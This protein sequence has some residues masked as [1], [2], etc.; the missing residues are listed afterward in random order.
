[1]DFDLCTPA[2]RRNPN[3][4]SK[5]RVQVEEDDAILEHM[6]G[7]SRD[8]NQIREAK[9]K[10]KKP[11]EATSPCIEAKSSH[12]CKRTRIRYQSKKPTSKEEAHVEG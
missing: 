12:R 9:R 4:E 5:A 11:A 7:D 8:M 1:L 2:Q 3:G 6:M 10:N